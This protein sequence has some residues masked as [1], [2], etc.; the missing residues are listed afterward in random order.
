MDFYQYV[1][2]GY[3]ET[4]GIPV[5]A[6]RGFENHD[7]GG[8]PAVMINEALAKRFFSDRDPIGGRLRPS[9]LG[10]NA[11]WLNVIGVLKDVKQ[12]GVAEVVG[13]ELYILTEQMPKYGNFA[14]GSMNFVVRSSL[15]LSSLASEYRQ[16]EGQ[17]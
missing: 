15:P 14:P 16:A 9:G 13:T 4:M 3:V 12:G 17:E 6:G 1:M 8:A 11:P 10:L 2:V 7:V 5:V